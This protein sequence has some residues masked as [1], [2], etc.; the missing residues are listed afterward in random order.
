MDNK[1]FS[2]SQLYFSFAVFQPLA[3]LDVDCDLQK[4]LC[5]N[6]QLGCLCS[7]CSGAT[8]QLLTSMS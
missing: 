8:V 1:L 7:K 3:S 5:R 6:G 2:S 4:L